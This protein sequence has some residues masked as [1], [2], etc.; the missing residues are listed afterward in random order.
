MI[1]LDFSAASSILRETLKGSTVLEH[2]FMGTCSTIAFKAY[3]QL[4]LRPC[5][6]AAPWRNN[7]ARFWTRCE[8]L[9]PSALGPPSWRGL[10]GVQWWANWYSTVCWVLR[11]Q[12]LYVRIG[13]AYITVLLHARIHSH[14]ELISICCTMDSLWWEARTWP[15]NSQ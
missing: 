12:M 11:F 10:K 9:G 4:D 2:L 5:G 13:S 8:P 7:K 14:N 1:D 6:P 15:G 3:T